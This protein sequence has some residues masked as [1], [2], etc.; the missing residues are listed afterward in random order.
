MSRTQKTLTASHTRDQARRRDRRLGD[1]V[2]HPLGNRHDGCPWPNLPCW[3]PAADLVE[4]SGAVVKELTPAVAV[5][6]TQFP[7]DFPRD[8]ADRLIGATART[9]ELDAVHALQ[10]L[11]LVTRDKGIRASTLLNT[12]W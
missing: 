9:E 4:K 6:S 1:C 3:D 5:L 12:V 2:D 8:P 10:S 11:V 7:K